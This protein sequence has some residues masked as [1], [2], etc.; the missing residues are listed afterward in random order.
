MAKLTAKA[1][2]AIPTSKF[3]GPKRSYPDQDASHA[4]NAL[5]RVANKSPALKARVD[6]KVHRDWPGMGEKDKGAKKKAMPRRKDHAGKG[7]KREAK[8]HDA[9]GHHPGY[10]MMT[11]KKKR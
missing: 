10:S 5:A 8:G 6:A 11:M 4:R 2:K 3:A 9:I 1:R 7:G